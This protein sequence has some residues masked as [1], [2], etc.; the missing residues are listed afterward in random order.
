[1]SVSL[2]L[3]PRIVRS[4]T[5]HSVLGA[6]PGA[7]KFETLAVNES[8]SASW[9][10]L[11]LGSSSWKGVSIYNTPIG[12]VSPLSQSACCRCGAP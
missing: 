5:G 3:S 9:G 12:N 11:V 4:E 1:M 2:P 7:N 8:L 6:L 10:A